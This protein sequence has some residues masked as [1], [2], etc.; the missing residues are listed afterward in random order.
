MH[1][2]IAA[3]AAVILLPSHAA[4]VGST[5]SD[6]ATLTEQPGALSVVMNEEILE[7]E[8]ADSAN[9]LQLTD[10]SGLFYGDGC[11]SV[12]GDTISLDAE[13]G[14]AGEYA[15]TYQIVSGD[16]HA[17]DGTIAF[18][19]DPAEGEEGGAGSPTAP[20]CGEAPAPAEDAEDATA[21]SGAV[22]PDASAV[23]DEAPDAAATEA[24][25]EG[26]GGGFPFIAVGVLAI[27]A[28][29]AVVAYTVNRGSRQRRDGA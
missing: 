11:A 19:F 20:V 17:V 28:V 14:G 9:R 25:A 3:L 21:T 8:G 6:G 27:L 2:A 12:E 15:L 23:A 13:L 7:I 5:P 1:A 16:G 10:A 22:A 26:E 29:L 18:S 24:P 4:V